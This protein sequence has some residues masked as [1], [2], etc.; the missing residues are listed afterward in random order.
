MEDDGNWALVTGAS[1]RGGAAIARL[2]HARGLNV[3][4]HRSERSR[5][6]AEAELASLLALRPDSARVWEADFTDPAFRVPDWVAQLPVSVLVCN[7]SRYCPSSLSD[8]E[9]FAI[10]WTLHVMAHVRI[11]QALGCGRQGAPPLALRSIIGISDIA[12][13]RAPPGY[14]SYTVAK[15]ALETLILALA[16]ELAPHVRCNVVQPGTLPFP[17]D[18]HDSERAARIEASIPL[19]RIG[20]FAE[21]A[22]T[23]V[24]LA[25]DAHYIT[26][27]VLAV[28]GGRSRMLV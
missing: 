3:I 27:Q 13:S 1:G 6:A 18:W 9:A 16:N 12:A 26:G 28:D 2:L 20:S 23:V 15:G 4:L 19:G 25:L 22:E 7:A 11:M 24:F 14:I 17:E 8:T 10:D 21:L 5:S